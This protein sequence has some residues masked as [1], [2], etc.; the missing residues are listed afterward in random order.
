MAGLAEVPLMFLS[1]AQ[2]TDII[3]RS[4]A[5]SGTYYLKKP[6]DAEVLLELVENVLREPRTA[7]THLEFAAAA[8]S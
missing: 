7:E 5:G 8:N 1:A 2:S 4:G 3:R 6:V